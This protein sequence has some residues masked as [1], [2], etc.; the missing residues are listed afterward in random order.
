[1]CGASIFD[2]QVDAVLLNVIDEY[3]RSKMFSSF[4]FPMRVHA[5]SMQQRDALL[6]L[7]RNSINYQWASS[8]KGWR[9]QP[10]EKFNSENI[11]EKRTK[12]CCAAKQYFHWMPRRANGGVFIANNFE[13]LNFAGGVFGRD[14]PALERLLS[15]YFSYWPSLF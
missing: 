12:S 10:M 9:M 13:L 4:D 11:P 3:V 6:K 5:H 1:L 7:K 8:Q 14:F 2:R 15:S